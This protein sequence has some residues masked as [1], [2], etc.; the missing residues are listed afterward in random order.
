[1]TEF[2]KFCYIYSAMISAYTLETQYSKPRYSKI[3]DIVNKTQLPSWGFIE[4]LCLDT[5]DDSIYIHSKQK[6]SDRLVY[7][8]KSQVYIQN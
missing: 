7:Y 4:I 2:L 1:M 6:G 3:L 5:V 8:I